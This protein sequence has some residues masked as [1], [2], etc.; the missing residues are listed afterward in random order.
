MKKLAYVATAIALEAAVSFAGPRVGKAQQARW[1][2]PSV[3]I[4]LALRTMRIFA[5]KMPSLF[6]GRI[7]DPFQLCNDL[8]TCS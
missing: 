8:S 2:T 4:M 1:T 6:C 5:A 7:A 3:K